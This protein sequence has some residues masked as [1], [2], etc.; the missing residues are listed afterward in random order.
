MKFRLRAIAIEVQIS[1]MSNRNQKS[2]KFRSR[3]LVVKI[4]IQTTYLRLL[5][6]TLVKST[7]NPVQRCANCTIQEFSRLPK[8]SM[9]TDSFRT[10]IL[11][12]QIDCKKTHPKPA[13]NNRVTKVTPELFSPTSDLSLIV[14]ARPRSS[15]I[16]PSNCEGSFLPVRFDPL[17]I[18]SRS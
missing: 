5:A 7:L 2:E 3:L 6:A 15:L 18:S 12:F 16:G 11:S 9:K 10:H 17:T 13:C 14:L 8:F 1:N 4:E